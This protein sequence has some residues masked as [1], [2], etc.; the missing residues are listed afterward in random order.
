MEN[1][2]NQKENLELALQ[3]VEE[4]GKMVEG[5]MYEDYLNS[6]L[7]S[8]QV[9]FKRQLSLVKNGQEVI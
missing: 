9:E 3:K 8:L 5:M 7:I 4:L 1:Q 6:K 2:K